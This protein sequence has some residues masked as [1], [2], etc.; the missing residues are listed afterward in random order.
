MVRGL[1]YPS[2]KGYVKQL[3][4]ILFKGRVCCINMGRGVMGKD[5][6]SSAGGPF[7]SK[8]VCCTVRNRRVGKEIDGSNGY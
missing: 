8:G 1:V 7:Y 4:N 3:S 5:G 2:D 6:F